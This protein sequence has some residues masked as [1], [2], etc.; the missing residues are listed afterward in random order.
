MQK[1]LLIVA[2]RINSLLIDNYER[3][4]TELNVIL[5]TNQCIPNS[6]VNYQKVM[7]RGTDSINMISVNNLK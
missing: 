6:I 3:A 2:T 4:I 5:T 7:N 1:H